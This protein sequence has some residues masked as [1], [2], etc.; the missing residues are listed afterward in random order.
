MAR[1]SERDETAEDTRAASQWN[2][3]HE[4]QDDPAAEAN[5]MEHV[6]VLYKRRWTAVTVFVVVVVAIMLRTVNA[7]PIFEA[8]VQLLI[9]A[10]AP[11][12]LNF[13]EVLAD[14]Q[15]LYD[16]KFA[17]TQHKLLTS[18]SLARKTIDALDLWEH[19]YLG[20]AN[21]S[22][23]A[24]A[25]IRGA[26]GTMTSRML[27]LVRPSHSSASSSKPEIPAADENAVES[28]VIDAFLAGLVV[29]PLEMSRLVDVVYR[30]PDAVFATT[31]I[32]ELAR[33][34][35]QQ[36]LELRF[37]ASKDASDWLTQQLA[38]Q[39][40]EVEASELALQRFREEHDAVSLDDGQNIVVQKLAALNA[41]VTEAKNERINKEITYERLREMSGN[42]D[43]LDA[44]PAILSN[45]FIQELKSELSRLQQVRSQLSE[46]LGE[47]HPE[48]TK[49]HS[50]VETAEQKLK[51]EIGKVVESVR[52]EY[53]TAADREQ[54]LTAALN[55]QKDE[56][57]AQNRKAIAY[58]AIER[59]AKSNRQTYDTLLQRLQETGLSE[60]LR[61][62]NVRIV[63]VAE[64]PRTPTGPNRRTEFLFAILIGSVAAIGMVFGL[65]YID[66]RIKTPDEITGHLHLPCLGLVP[67]APEKQ[68][69]AAPLINNGAPAHF[70][71]A[72]RAL[73]TNVLFS[74][75]D[76]G[77]RMIVITSTGS[78][79]GKTVIASNL[80]LALAQAHQR[81]LLIDADMRRP[82][83][84]SY[85]SHG[86]EPGLS[87][88]IVGESE[89][90]EVVH[91][92]GTAGLWLLPSGRIPPNPAELLGSGRFKDF[93]ASMRERFDWIIIDTPPV[94]A[95]TDA[96]LMAHMA[97]G[98]LFVVGAEMTNR[99]AAKR[100]LKQLKM[101]RAGFI[102]GI[103]NRVDIE[104]N[105]YYYASYYGRGYGAY[106]AASPAHN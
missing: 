37:N 72:F 102:G 92:S 3:T 80:A 1:R 53:L 94:M 99:N 43:A 86:Q 67:A 13:N 12:V 105:G 46:T 25:G 40:K 45:T 8:R 106:H 41:A 103:L 95:V 10:E 90:G 24:P 27:A 64:V 16:Y 78:S 28:Q 2:D 66:N 49:A 36:N 83:V 93:L 17:E 68:I 15:S 71:E 77:S 79:E 87:N 60:E 19:P 56:A 96:C 98:V 50:A 5:I 51:A 88:F 84:H 89:A 33:Q 21:P 62:T 30:S 4:T 32:N 81:V 34:Y 7:I 76:E 69:G 82:Q 65:E 6:R 31:I 75:V 100:A 91:E 59:D 48:M 61:A 23:S 44:F 39:R 58:G 11:K 42:P 54:T 97:N 38:E 63:D 101:A 26:I 73:R 52:T 14:G 18:R 22:T 29:A 55:T 47:K 35:I 20:G 74:S 70:S 57:L 85:F 9:D 104:N